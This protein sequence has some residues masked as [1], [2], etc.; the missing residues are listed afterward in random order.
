MHSPLSR[1]KTTT[2]FEDLGDVDLVIEAV[3]ENMNVK[4]E[5][6]KKL[7][8]SNIDIPNFNLKG[9]KKNE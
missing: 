6:F 8:A 7:D 3:F 1:I 5:T 9:G 2:K 4:K